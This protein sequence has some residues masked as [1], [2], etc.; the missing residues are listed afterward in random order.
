MNISLN[1]IE[2]DKAI[3]AYVGSL[4][5]NLVGKQVT[6]TMFAGRKDNGFKAEVEIVEALNSVYEPTTI[7]AVEKVAQQLELPIGCP[8]SRL[9]PEAEIPSNALD[10]NPT[11]KSLFD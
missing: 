1:S 8:T 11:S 3:T 2:I 6:I 4:G 10:D 9:E 5:V 7:K